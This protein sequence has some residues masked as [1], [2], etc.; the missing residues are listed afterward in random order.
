MANVTLHS[1]APINH[2][3]SPTA[4]TS[5]EVSDRVC[6]FG[7]GHP[8]G[9]NFALADG[10]VRFLSDRISLPTLQALSTRSGEEAIA[11]NY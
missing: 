5:L 9:A 2:A 11:E 3:L 10:S 4:N 7:S 6:A 8:K 1:A